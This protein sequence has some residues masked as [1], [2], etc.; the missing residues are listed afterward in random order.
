MLTRPALALLLFGFVQAAPAVRP[1]EDA[2]A[3][4]VSEAD[5]RRY[6]REL[7]AFGP[8]M[9]GTPSN[10]KSAAYLAAFFRT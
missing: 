10:E 3:G 1:A 7:V 2:F 8:R 6:V 4:A 5:L 9:G